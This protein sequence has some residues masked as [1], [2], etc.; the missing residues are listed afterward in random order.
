MSRP[1]IQHFY[2][3]Q[4]GSLSYVIS[5]PD[6]KS[7]AIIDPVLG[8]SAVSGRIDQIR[9][10]ER[11]S[12]TSRRKGLSRRVDSGNARACRS[13]DGCPIP[14]VGA[15][16]S[17]RD[18]AGHL[19]CAGALCES[20]QYAGTFQGRRAPV[21]QAFLRWRFFPDWESRLPGARHAGPYGRQRD[22]PRGRCRICWRQPVHV[23][24]RY[25]PMRLSRRGRGSVV[26]FDPEALFAGPMRPVC[27][28]ATTI[29][30]KGAIFGSSARSRNKSGT[31]FMS[32][33]VYRSV[34]SSTC[35]KKETLRSVCRS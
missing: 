25:G 8:F 2:D 7:A 18:R 26:R 31:V 4:T 19:H 21:R 20:I 15:W 24:F 16:R 9:C 10:P 14:E 22:L 30:P 35:E 33:T 28:C 1:G 34:S 6:S 27:S 12:N 5:D 13:S 32:V 3:E 29:H 23:R 17:G 11:L